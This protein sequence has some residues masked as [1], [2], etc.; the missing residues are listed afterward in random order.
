MSRPISNKATKF[1]K[2]IDKYG[3]VI[4]VKYGPFAFLLAIILAL[5]V[6]GVIR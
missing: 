4:L 2:I 3:P 1:V 5:I 6:S